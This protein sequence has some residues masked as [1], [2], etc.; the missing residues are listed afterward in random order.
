MR[1]L[2]RFGLTVAITTFMSPIAASSE[3][4]TGI[5]QDETGRFYSL[6]GD[7]TRC[8]LIDYEKISYFQ[9]ER[10]GAYIGEFQNGSVLLSLVY[11]SSLG[12]NNRFL[13]TFES[14]HSATIILD[15][16]A[17]LIDGPTRR[18]SRIF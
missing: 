4:C 6:H 13:L 2:I 3:S 14:T 5:W 15:P 16:S 12:N 11:E 8:V 17:V 10:E 1:P 9:N 7:E 18:I